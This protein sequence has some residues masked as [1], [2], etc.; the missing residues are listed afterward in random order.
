[1]AVSWEKMSKEERKK[2][3]E[4]HM[5]DGFQVIKPAPKKSGKKSK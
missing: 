5:G 3:A 4:R 2:R 1:M